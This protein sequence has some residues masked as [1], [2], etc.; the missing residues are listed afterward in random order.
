MSDARDETS[1]ETPGLSRRSFL[2]IAA[3]AGGGLAVGF[4]VQGCRHVRGTQALGGGFSP[5]AWV[6]ITA[7]DQVRFFVDNAE[8]GQGVATSHVQLLCE[9]LEIAPQRVLV[10]FAP[11]DLHSFGVQLTGGST[12][13]TSR[14]DVVRTAGATAR[15]LLRRAAARRWG[16]P[17]AEVRA[18]DG[19]LLHDARGSLRY[20]EVAEAAASE[21]VHLGEVRLKEPKDWRVIG[22]PMRRI[23]GPAKADGSAR[24]GLDV[25]VPGQLTAVVVR[26]P[27]LHG[28]L[29]RIVDASK[30]RAQAGVV[31]VVAIPQGVAVVADSYWRARKAAALLELEWDAGKLT[32][33][34]SSRL[35]ETQKVL[36]REQARHVS[37]RG[38]VDAALATAAKRLRA[39]YEVPYLAHATMEPMNATAH[40]EEERCRVWVPTQSP[41][42][43]KE[44]VARLTG[45]PHDKIDVTTTFLGGGF[46]RRGAADFVAEAVEISKAVRAPVQVVWSREDD[47]RHGQFRPASMALLEG[48]VDERGLPV[49]WSH[50]L[51]GQSIASAF[52]NMLGMVAPELIPSSAMD[53]LGGAIG[54]LFVDGKI[55][56][57]L[58]VEGA[59][60]HPYAIASSRTELAMM[61]SDIPVFPWRSVGHSINAFV[62]ESFVDELA[63]LGGRDPLE[64]RRALLAEHPRHRGVLDAA[65]KAIG[66][67]TPPPAGRF[68]GIAQHHCFGSWCA[69]AV[70]IS[71]DGGLRVHRVV[72]AIDCGR[73]VNPD[74]I[75]AQM[76]GGVLYG[77]SAALL[78]R[79][80]IDKGR[81]VQGNFHDFPLVR[82]PDAPQVETVIVRSDERPTGVGEL[83]VP[84]LAP[85]LAN[86]FFAATGVRLRRLPLGPDVALVLE[87]K[88]PEAVTL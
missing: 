65:A 64:L 74:L 30:A 33:F 29:V 26:P 43:T 78:Q 19:A 38:D 15:E 45:L 34:S 44:V 77:L 7:D 4:L 69:E 37:S 62:V 14:F 76:E 49:A 67:G 13:T 51:T 63:H 68:R 70:E 54:K 80:T 82:M 5:N 57:P 58:A 9:E 50:R 36:V 28:R 12:S 85:A 2:Q 35:H 41:T 81:V 8:M 84:P 23:D 66:W 31:D 79:I 48:A 11:A 47:I 87:G 10:E 52:A 21:S 22:Q 25:R 1:A 18:V 53:L 55:V 32:S 17:L 3:V 71:I 75:A 6:R 27:V 40:V 73:A 59:G 16:V 20:G 88:T 83:A 56:D 39:V 46:G 72:C 24:F 60:D 42:I 86:A 61:P